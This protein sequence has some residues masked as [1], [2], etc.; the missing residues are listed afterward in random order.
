[1]TMVEGR[2]PSPAYWNGRRVLVTGHTG[3]KGSW[4]TAWLTEMGAEVAGLSLPGLPTSPAL[5][6]SLDVA[7][8]R[9]IRSDICT[10]GWQGAVVDFDPQVILHLAAR[11]LVA[12]GYRQPVTTFQTNVMGTAQVLDLTTKVT[13]LESVLVATTDKVYDPHGQPP[14]SESSPLGGVDPYSASKACAEMVVRSWPHLPVPVVTARAGNVIGGGDWSGHRLVPDLV[15]S[16][17]AGAA[18]TIRQP[19]AIRPWQHVLEPL[20]GYLVYLE[21]VAEQPDLPRAMNFGPTIAQ[22]VAVREVARLAA[23]EWA[24]LLDLPDL[25]ACTEPGGPTM[26]ETHT[27][28]IDSSQAGSVLGWRSRLGWQSAVEMTMDWYAGHARGSDTTA[29]LHEQLRR[30][31]A[32]GIEAAR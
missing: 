20:G 17:S 3:F 9:D 16:W 15:R 26:H 18:A 32:P 5:W 8:A 13:S 14:Y 19:S 29:L 30:Y 4:L 7:L 2:L 1:M 22:E 31:A 6:G 23:Q 27:L 25:P 10:D 24:R 12:D 11:A 21:R 28:T